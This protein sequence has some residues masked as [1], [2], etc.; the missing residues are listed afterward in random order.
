MSPD[1]KKM[2]VQTNSK[3]I[4]RRSYTADYYIYNIADRKLE[5]FRITASSSRLYGRRME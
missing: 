3:K 4:Y 2:L 1:G 5:N